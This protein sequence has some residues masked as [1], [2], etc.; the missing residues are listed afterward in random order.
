M[1]KFVAALET[2]NILYLWLGYYRTWLTKIKINKFKWLQKKRKNQEKYIFLYS[3]IVNW[4][5]FKFYDETSK[6]EKIT[7]C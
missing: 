4:Y 1:I 6:I 5:Y 7:G 2:N 3:W